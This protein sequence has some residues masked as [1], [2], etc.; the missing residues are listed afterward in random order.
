MPSPVGERDE[1]VKR[2]CRAG[3]IFLRAA[4]LALTAMLLAGCSGGGNT[5]TK[6]VAGDHHAKVEAG[7]QH[8]F[9]TLHP[10]DSIFPTGAG[11][12]RVKNNGCK[13][14]H[15]KWLLP[16]GSTT[17][18]KGEQT[19]ALWQCFVRFKNFTVTVHVAAVNDSADVVW[20]MPVYDRRAPR[21]SLHVH[22]PADARRREQPAFLE[23]TWS[24][25]ADQI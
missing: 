20:A 25:P 24:Q 6:V 11:P 8:Y 15:R 17:F 9:S 2:P 21:L 22:T 10:Q 13:D 5:R 7:L 3:L 23:T 4:A 12:P 19:V 14:L 1:Q 16:P 18:K